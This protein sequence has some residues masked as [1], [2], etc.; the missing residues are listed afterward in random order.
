MG[1][2]F[3]FFLTQL[4]FLRSD[5][6]LNVDQCDVLPV[7]RM[8]IFHVGIFLTE[9]TEPEGSMKAAILNR[10]DAFAVGRGWARAIHLQSG[11]SGCEMM[12]PSVRSFGE[13]LRSLKSLHVKSSKRLQCSTHRTII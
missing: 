10:W 1:V 11:W 5:Y 9:S 13:P 6:P 12:V 4:R 3:V 7:H 8:S 2:T